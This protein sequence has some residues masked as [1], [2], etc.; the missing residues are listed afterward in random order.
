MRLSYTPV[1]LVRTTDKLQTIVD[2]S[3][4]CKNH[5]HG[6]AAVIDREWKRWE[7][8]FPVQHY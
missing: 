1:Q 6:T 2:T 8:F 5:K 7:S 4:T 3:A